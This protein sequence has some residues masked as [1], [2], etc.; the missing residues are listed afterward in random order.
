MSGVVLFTEIMK[1]KEKRKKKNNPQRTEE[2][3]GTD[4]G[5]PCGA[6]TPA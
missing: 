6:G 5:G 1:R 4:T 2:E 3:D